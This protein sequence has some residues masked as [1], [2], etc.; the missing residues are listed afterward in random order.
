MPRPKYYC[1]KCERYHYVDS[2]IGKQHWNNFMKLWNEYVRP[3]NK[4]YLDYIKS[5]PEKIGGNMYDD[6]NTPEISEVLK[7]HYALFKQKV[8]EYLQ[9]EQEINKKHL[10]LI[11]HKVA[12]L[13][14]DFYG[15]APK[16]FSEK[17]AKTKSK[18]KNKT[19]LYH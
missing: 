2:S 6:D 10:H 3:K 19:T 15:G 18:S 13:G 16:E 7:E 17:K 5:L 12:D 1:S 4:M 11:K 14:V 9:K 8:P